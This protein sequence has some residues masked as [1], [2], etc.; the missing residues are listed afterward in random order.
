VLK[1]YTKYKRKD[2]KQNNTKEKPN[3]FVKTKLNQEL[4]KANRLQQIYS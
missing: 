4:P 1:N 3:T 2:I